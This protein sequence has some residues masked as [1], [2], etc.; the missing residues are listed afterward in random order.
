MSAARVALLT[1]SALVAFAANSVL[2][3]LALFGASIDPATFS[4]VRI[5]TGA[6]TIGV[7]VATRQGGSLRAAWHAGTWRGAL[8]LVLYAFPFSYAYVDLSAGVGALLLFGTVQVTMILYA[9]ATGERLAAIQW[10]GLALAFAGLTYLSFPGIEAP[11]LQGSALMVLAGLGWGGYSLVGRGASRP[12]RATAGNFL[13]ASP[14][15]LAFAAT[16]FGPKLEGMHWS[17]AGLAWS[18]ASGALASGLGY[19]LWYAALAHLSGVHAAV[20]QLSVPLLAAIGGLLFLSESPSTRLVVA[21]GGI[22][23]GVGLT[24]LGRRSVRERGGG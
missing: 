22:L 18:A 6:V 17:S 21:A 13:R 11:S 4:V 8:L 10:S 24:V 5:L 16:V 2:C 15:A 12:L 7:L 14:F 1:G 23:G 3:R 9:L 19:A 20:V